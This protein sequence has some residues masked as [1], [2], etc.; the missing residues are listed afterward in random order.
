MRSADMRDTECDHVQMR[1][2]W[3]LGTGHWKIRPAG[4]LECDLQLETETGDWDEWNRLGRDGL[5]WVGMDG[6]DW[7]GLG[8]VGLGWVRLGRVGI[9][10]VGM[11][12]VG[13][14]RLGRIGL[15]R[16]AVGCIGSACTEWVGLGWDGWVR[17]P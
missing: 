14:V 17:L 16:A 15:G 12:W 5:G 8:W 10:R 7:V 4:D 6:F 1:T 13:S 3:R 11:G 2:G 9:G